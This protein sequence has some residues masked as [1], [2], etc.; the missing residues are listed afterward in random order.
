MYADKH[1]S[2]WTGILKIEN[3]S[4]TLMSL[5]SYWCRYPQRLSLI[6]TVTP[7]L[8]GSYNT[9]LLTLQATYRFPTWVSCEWH[10]NHSHRITVSLVLDLEKKFFL[11]VC[12]VKMF[13]VFL[14]RSVCWFVYGPFVMVPLNLIYLQC[15]QHSFFEHLFIYIGTPDPLIRSQTIYKYVLKVSW[16]QKQQLLSNMMI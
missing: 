13:N 4:I 3:I 2:E 9:S 15:L 5:V 1:N 7:V 10:L 12:C 8:P 16:L 6:T 14:C 11:C